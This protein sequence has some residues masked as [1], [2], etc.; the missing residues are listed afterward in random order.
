MEVAF[1]NKGKLFLISIKHYLIRFL[2]GVNL[3]DDKLKI[4]N[5]GVNKSN[6]ELI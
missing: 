1:Q 6:K 5:L 3:T 2:L 4:P